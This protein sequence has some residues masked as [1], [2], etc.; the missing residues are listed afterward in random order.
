MIRIK[1]CVI[2]MLAFALAFT[3]MLEYAQHVANKYEDD[4]DNEDDKTE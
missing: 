2:A 4:E 3:F 1:F